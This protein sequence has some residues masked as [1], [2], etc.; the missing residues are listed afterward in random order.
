MHPLRFNS[1]NSHY[2]IRKNRRVPTRQTCIIF[3]EGETEEGYFKKFKTRCKTVKGGSMLKI[4][5]EAIVQKK[6]L[7]RNY[8]Q[9]WLVVDKDRTSPEHFIF[10]IQMAE[11][12]GIQVAFSC[13]SFEIWWLFHFSIINSRVNPIDY[14]EKIKK[15]VHDYSY[16]DKG[17]LQGANMWLALHSRLD[18][19]ISNARKAHSQCKTT[20]EAYY[21]SVTTV[22]QL[23]DF[24][25]KQRPF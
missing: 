3:T 1:T 12:N 24:L 7:M 20:N 19:A 23:A 10:A 8:D 4:V 5:E 17:I 25:N 2:P 9:Y 15:Y 14:E 18:S 6:N 22:Y 16:R 11:M 13:D 21:Q